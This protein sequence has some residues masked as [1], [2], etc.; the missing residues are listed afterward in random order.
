LQSSLLTTE[1]FIDNIVGFYFFL[2][3]NTDLR[4]FD[5]RFSRD[6]REKMPEHSPIINV[7]IDTCGDHSWNTAY[8]AYTV[9]IPIPYGK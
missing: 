6:L 1:E 8:G 9:P 2:G 3:G 7:R 5:K 4:G